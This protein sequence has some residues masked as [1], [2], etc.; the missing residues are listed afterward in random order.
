MNLRKPI[1]AATAIAALAIP[2]T[3]GAYVSPLSLSQAKQAARNA[4]WGF[5]TPGGTDSVKITWSIRWSSWKVVLGVEADGTKTSR[6]WNSCQDISYSTYSCIGGWD[7][8][9]D[10]TWAMGTVDVFKSSRTGRVWTQLES[11]SMSTW[12]G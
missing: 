7:Y 3:A 1:L 10:S 4:G 5:P 2:A 12:G 11:D 6:T 9:T 8:S